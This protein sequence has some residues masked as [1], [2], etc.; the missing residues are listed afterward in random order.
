M[1]VVV[2]WLLVAVCCPVVLLANSWL[3]ALGCYI[4]AV[5]SWLVI[6]GC[7]LLPASSWL[8][9]PGCYLVAVISA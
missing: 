1:M 2:C 3:L 6:N 5:N 7:E 8:L 9:A 4:L